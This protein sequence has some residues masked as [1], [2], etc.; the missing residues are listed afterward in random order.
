LHAAPWSPKPYT[1][2]DA[3]GGT[4]DQLLS[5]PQSLAGLV[6]YQSGSV[7]SRILFRGPG[8]TMT[9]F[10]FSE[11]QGLDEHTN[12]NDAIVHVLDGEASVRIADV[13]HRVQEGEALHLPPSAPHAVLEGSEFKMLLIL[14]KVPRPETS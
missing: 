2:V 3:E 4:V 11:G 8:G 12:P 1:F 10:A 14:L 5:T 6:D 7:V 9:V 13:T